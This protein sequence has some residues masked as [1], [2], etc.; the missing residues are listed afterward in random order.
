MLTAAATGKPAFEGYKGHGVFTYALMEALHKGDSN[1]N[2]KIELTELV[3]HVEKRVPELVAELDKHGGVVKGI[4]VMAMRG[5]NGDKQSAHFG[6]TGEDFA[7]V[8]RL[9]GTLP[10]V[11]RIQQFFGSSRVTIPKHQWKHAISRRQHKGSTKKKSVRRLN[12]ARKQQR[13]LIWLRKHVI[14]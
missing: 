9:P 11:V 13:L 7:I 8:Q 6:S 12:A 3:A 4:A 14:P 5:A 1:N 2:G 10:N